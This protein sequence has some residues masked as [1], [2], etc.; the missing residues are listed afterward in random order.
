[1]AALR[2]IGGRLLLVRDWNG[3]MHTGIPVDGKNI[4][5]LVATYDNPFARHWN[6]K[7]Y[8]RYLAAHIPAVLVPPSARFLS[9]RIDMCHQQD[10]I[11]FREVGTHDI[12]VP[13][14]D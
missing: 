6:S 13:W 11:Y 8:E 9:V 5:R 1:M 2:A 4:L 10:G 7:S 14:T 3:G 12:D